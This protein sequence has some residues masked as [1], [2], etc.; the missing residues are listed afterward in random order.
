MLKIWDPRQAFLVG[1]GSLAHRTGKTVGGNGDMRHACSSDMEW[2][3]PA[4]WQLLAEEGTNAHRLRTFQDGWLDRYG[5]WVVW[6]RSGR[7][8]AGDD[9]VRMSGELTSRFG[10]VPRGWFVRHVER[11]ARD[12]MPARLMMGE[13]PGNV[14]VR[15]W[16]VLY[17]VEPGGGYSSGLFLDQRL[18]RR[19]VLS[20]RPLRTLN[21]FA[22]TCSFSVC[23][24]LRGSTTLNVDVSKRS[25]ARG[26]ENFMLNGLDPSGGHRFLAEDAVKIV[27]RLARRGENFDLVVLDP[28]TFGRSDRGVFRIVDELPSLVQGCAGLLSPGGLLLVSCNYSRWSASDL[29]E[30]CMAVLSAGVFSITRGER[31]SEIPS[32]AVSWWIRRDANV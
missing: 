26:K 19:R 29:L 8:V 11:S 3:S 2:I 1:N 16:N 18:N 31:P 17:R 21:L 14:D 4:Q 27:P 23:A 13:D 30:V 28:P 7:P 32:G 9:A 20:S 15:E 22:Y 25:L 12:Q 10:F 24:A 6:S 5:E